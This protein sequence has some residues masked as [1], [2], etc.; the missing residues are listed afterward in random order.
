[1][2]PEPRGAGSAG[3]EGVLGGSQGLLLTHQ[4]PLDD[5]ST[6]IFFLSDNVPECR[7]VSKCKTSQLNNPLPPK[8]S[9]H[10]HLLQPPQGDT[11]S[12]LGPGLCTQ[13]RPNVIRGA[14]GRCT[15]KTSSTRRGEGGRHTSTLGQTGFYH[16]L[17]LSPESQLSDAPP[18]R[19][20]LGQC[21]GLTPRG[22]KLLSEALLPASGVLFLGQD[23]Y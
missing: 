16:P 19:T 4:R 9:N 20:H 14:S 7:M 15:R 21:P 12:N 2:A 22:T 1:M 5:S 18:A 17:T 13:S 8:I 6:P 3:E 11:Q 23:F 10:C